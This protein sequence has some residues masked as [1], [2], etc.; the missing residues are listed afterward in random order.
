MSK[1]WMDK[2]W[3]W[4]HCFNALALAAGRPDLATDQFR[5]V[6]DHQD[7]SGALPDSI[8]HSEVL[9]NFVKP[10]I[11]G[12]ALHGIRRRLHHD[13]DLDDLVQVYRQ[14][15]SWTSFWLT[16]RRVPGHTLAYYQHGNDSGWDNS[17]TF[18]D[19]RVV[20]TADLAAFLSLQMM[21]LSD[22]AREIGQPAEATEWDQRA[23]EMQAAMITELWDGNRFAARDP[24]TG[25]LHH[26]DSLLNLMPLILGGHL[27][28][29]IS[30]GLINQLHNHITTWGLAT[31]PPESPQYQSDGYW[32]GPIWAPSTVLLE[33]GLRRGGHPDLADEINAK[34]RALCEQSGFAENFDALTGTG[35]RDR[36]YTWTA[37]AYLMLAADFETRAGGSRA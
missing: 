37:S 14:L 36:A 7:P 16:M 19:Q 34:F 27:P 33:D 10:P 17:T 11:H 1:H 3:S 25:E 2:V 6:F 13:L 8:T 31:E 30:V 15:S 22:L 23:R 35:L 26:S 4:D 28:A 12:W 9:Y 5:V 24:I 29:D 18:D 32:R 21:E 20:E